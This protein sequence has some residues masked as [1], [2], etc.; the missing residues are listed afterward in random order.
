MINCVSKTYLFPRTL[1][2][3]PRYLS[4]LYTSPTFIDTQ[5]SIWATPTGNQLFS[6]EV[7]LNEYDV[8]FRTAAKVKPTSL[9]RS[10]LTPYQKSVPELSFRVITIFSIRTKLHMIAEH[11]FSTNYVQ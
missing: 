10:S 2:L 7:P 5:E 6:V 9:S 1:I 8:R 4:W 3:D 11:Y